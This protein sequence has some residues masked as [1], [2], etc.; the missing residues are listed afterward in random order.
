MKPLLD[1][2]RFAGVLD[3]P[4]PEKRG[5]KYLSY[6]ER[7]I[8]HDSWQ[9]FHDDVFSLPPNA[10]RL[11]LPLCFDI[12]VRGG[13]LPGA[14]SFYGY[15]GDSL[16]EEIMEGFRLLGLPQVAG[17]L[18]QALAYWRKPDS[19]MHSDSVPWMRMDKDLDDVHGRYYRETEDLFARVGAMIAEWGEDGI[20]HAEH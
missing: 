6:I 7:Q 13:G 5:Q 18:G 17:F 16:V 11:Y 8:R 4:D 10:R 9:T 15:S 19:P 1:L 14:F 2:S 12:G 3:S 20:H